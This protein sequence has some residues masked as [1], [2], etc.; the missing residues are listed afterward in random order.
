MEETSRVKTKEVAEVIQIR[1]QKLITVVEFMIQ[2][3][4]KAAKLASEE[5]A[6]RREAWV[7]GA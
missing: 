4:K 7:A 6:R 2:I 5:E 1:H 3:L